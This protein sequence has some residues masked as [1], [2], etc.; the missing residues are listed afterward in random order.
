MASKNV[1]LSWLFESSSDQNDVRFSP[2]VAYEDY[3][4]FQNIDIRLKLGHDSAV[5]FISQ[6]YF[7]LN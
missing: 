5:T 1:L 3:A 4:G 6:D 2:V 7:T